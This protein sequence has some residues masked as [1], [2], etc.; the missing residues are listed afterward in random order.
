[1]ENVIEITGQSKS[2]AN[3]LLCSLGF[4]VTE[5]ACNSQSPDNF[6]LLS[7]FVEGTE[8]VSLS[9]TGN[10]VESSGVAK[11]EYNVEQSGAVEEASARLETHNKPWT[12][13]K[14]R[15][16][17]NHL[18]QKV[19]KYEKSGRESGFPN[20]GTDKNNIL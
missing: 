18:Q 6:D 9:D 10:I 16:Q 7:N 19:E 17:K 13:R 2:D 5:Y 12:Q 3:N 15:V 14:S 8:D 1:M 4:N 11:F 20:W